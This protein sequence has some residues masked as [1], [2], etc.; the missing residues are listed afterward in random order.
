[1]CLDCVDAYVVLTNNMIDY[2]GINSVP[3]IVIE[4]IINSF[5]IQNI[6]KDQNN[7]KKILFY[8]GSLCKR[9]GILNLLQAFIATTNPSFQLWICGTGDAKSLVMDYQNKDNRIKYYGQLRHEKILEMQIEATLLINP[10]TSEG[11]Y[12]M[13]SFPSKTMEYMLS[14]TPVL[15]NY[16]S[17]IPMEYYP[18]L[19]LLKDESIETLT[20]AIDYTLNQPASELIRFGE[21]AR[22]FVLKNK[23]TKEQGRK[24]YQLLYSLTVTE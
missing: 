2:L 18:Y 16:L 24:I 17:G 7:T 11:E 1:S 9:Y 8:A 19:K 5:P 23:D 22:E 21:I 15:M 6:K 12:T 3:Y 20:E 14:G 13:Y 10:R 4:G